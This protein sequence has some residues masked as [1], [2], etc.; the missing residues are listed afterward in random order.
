MSKNDSN[1]KMEAPKTT[2]LKNIY[3]FAKANSKWS[4]IH[5][6]VQFWQTDVAK[7][8][9]LIGWKKKIY[10]IG[11]S[12]LCVIIWHSR[13]WNVSNNIIIY[14]KSIQEKTK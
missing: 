14:L 11:P 10:G 6:R 3:D 8:N 13:S 9:S 4:F 2:W 7:N 12:A 5:Y 1:W